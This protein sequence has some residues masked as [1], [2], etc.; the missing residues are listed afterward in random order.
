[1]SVL[2]FQVLGSTMKARS[3]GTPALSGANAH[4]AKMEKQTFQPDTSDC[5]H[6]VMVLLGMRRGGSFEKRR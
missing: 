4:I 1:M 2:L 6:H 3:L 5:M